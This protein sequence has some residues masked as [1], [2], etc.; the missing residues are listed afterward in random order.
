MFKSSRGCYW[1]GVVLAACLC[2]VAQADE[3]VS[4]S[5]QIQPILNANC[6]ACHTPGKKKGKLDL[7]DFKVLSAGGKSGPAMVSGDPTTSLLIKQISGAEPEMPKEGDPLKPEEISLISRW[8]AQGAKDD[9]PVAAATP[10]GVYPPGPQP[11]DHPSL[12]LADPVI[13]AIAFSPDGHHLA[14]AGRYEILLHHVDGAGLERRIPSGSFR[15]TTLLFTGDGKALISAG[16]APGQY[17]QVQVWDTSDW[18]L[19][20][21][22]QVSGDTVFGANISPTGDRLVFGCADHTARILSLIDGRELLKSEQHTDWAFGAVFTTDGKV[23]ATAGRD[24]N[25]KRIELSN[26][27][28]AQELIEPA[29]PVTCIARHPVEDRIICGGS[30]GMLREYQLGKFEKRAEGKE[31]PN[32]IREL[33]RQNGCVNAIVFSSDGKLFAVAGA[34]EARVYKSTDGSRQ[35]ILR[36][37]TGPVYAVAFTPDGLRVATAGYDGQVRLFQVEGEK[38]L[39]SFAP[40]PRTPT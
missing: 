35:A 21:N 13:D 17:G 40:V 30:E 19:L 9:T 33:E 20:H 14:V 24:K 8:I 12:Y 3:P 26:P 22:Y 1:T 15:T 16:G 27:Q 10:A 23:I 2:A 6:V 4:Y 18:K 36:G 25:V 31:D 11:P 29:E 5:K 34:G 37:S 38:L 32:R 39:K 7:T 28:A